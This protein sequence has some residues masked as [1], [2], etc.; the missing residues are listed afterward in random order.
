[1]APQALQALSFYRCRHT[2]PGT[3]TDEWLAAAAAGTVPASV[4]P[5]SGKLVPPGGL[6]V[7]RAG[8]SVILGFDHYCFWIGAP[9]GLRNR[10]H[11]ILFTVYTGALAAIAAVHLAYELLVTPPP[12]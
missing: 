10:R 7:R 1:M 6:Y 4:C 9:V 11:F 2:N 3:V 12:E 8:E 5:R